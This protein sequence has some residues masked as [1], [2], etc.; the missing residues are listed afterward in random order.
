MEKLDGTAEEVARMGLILRSYRSHPEHC[1]NAL[2]RRAILCS[3]QDDGRLEKAGIDPDVLAALV[4]ASSRYIGKKYAWQIEVIRPERY[5]L[6][7]TDP[8]DRGGFHAKKPGGYRHL[9]DA[10]YTNQ[11]NP[12]FG[13]SPAQHALELARCYIHDSLHAATFRSYRIDRRCQSGDRIYREKY[14]FN[15]RNADG[16]SFSSPKAGHGEPLVINLNVLMDGIVD[17]LA[18][19]A[20][21][22]SVAL[23][24]WTRRIGDH[25]IVRECVEH[26]PVPTAG[27]DIFHADV[28]E[29]VKR[30]LEY[31]KRVDLIPC[32]V[33]AM[34]RGSLTSLKRAFE[35]KVLKKGEFVSLFKQKAFNRNIGRITAD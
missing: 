35:L 3:L 9:Y 22:H 4:R 29:P 11:L 15:L 5:F 27:A 32:A 34:K 14:G 33:Y 12:A 6:L 25:P 2:D 10:G 23:L 20:L 26:A 18:S 16:V 17:I 13:L 8:D 24:D 31:W 21:H 1:V 30:F 28:M 19:E 7:A